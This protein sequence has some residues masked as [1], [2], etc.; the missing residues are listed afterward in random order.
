[1]IIRWFN[2]EKKKIEKFN[3][4]VAKPTEESIGFSITDN[5]EQ[6]Q[7][8]AFSSY[9][10]LP[11]LIKF[12]IKINRVFKKILLLKTLSL[13]SD[14]K[15][16]YLLITINIKSIA[17][18]KILLEKFDEWADNLQYDANKIMYAIYEFTYDGKEWIKK[19]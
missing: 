17:Q 8:I 1:M 2:D 5:I 13:I 3:S 4:L 12:N 7:K 18:N 6:I 15:T 16:E 19:F 11:A 10:I 14:D 9:Y